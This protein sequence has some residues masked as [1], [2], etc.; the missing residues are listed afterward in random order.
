[1]LWGEVEFFSTALKGKKQWEKKGGWKGR[2]KKRH[3]TKVTKRAGG[4]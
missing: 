3:A 1:M 2:K 4:L